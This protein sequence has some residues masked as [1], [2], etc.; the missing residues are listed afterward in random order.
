LT[1][2]NGLPI[3]T[4]RISAPGAL[5]LARWLIF[6]GALKSAICYLRMTGWAGPFCNRRSYPK[7]IFFSFPAIYY[8]TFLLNKPPT[9]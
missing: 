9:A 4:I 5:G 1:S 3:W 6:R 2:L 7:K 8:F